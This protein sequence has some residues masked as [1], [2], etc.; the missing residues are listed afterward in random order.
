M[1]AVQNMLCRIIFGLRKHTSTSSKLKSLHWL[2]VKF[3]V[4]FKLMFTTY[5]TLHTAKP[6]YLKASLDFYNINRSTRC[7]SPSKKFLQVPIFNY[8]IH[9]SKNHFNWTFHYAAPSLWNSL[10]L[11][12]RAAPTAGAFRGRL[13][14]HLFSQA[15]PP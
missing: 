5:K 7:S 11:N 8:R 15:F 9:K 13:K 1:Q 14:A 12:V 4:I 2:P 10:P 3:R 6:P